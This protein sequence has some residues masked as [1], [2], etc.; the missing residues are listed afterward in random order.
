MTDVEQRLIA[1]R[2][3]V[4]ATLT[5]ENHKRCNCRK[6]I[7][8]G[9]WDKG[10]K[11]RIALTALEAHDA[12]KAEFEAYKRDAVAGVVEALEKAR[13]ALANRA[14]HGG[15]EL[16]CIRSPE[17]CRSDCGKVDGDALL[18]VEAAL[19][20]IKGGEDADG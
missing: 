19:T 10:Q 11:V 3:I 7:D 15:L 16:P 8:A 4:K 12:T 20:A 9:G 17:Q 18:A 13:E 6:E 2:E 1:A 14:C 5:P